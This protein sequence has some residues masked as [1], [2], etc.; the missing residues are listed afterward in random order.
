MLDSLVD[1]GRASKEMLRE[2][3]RSE[4]QELQER[5]EQAI[6]TAREIGASLDIVRANFNA[7]G[8]DIE[9]EFRD[10]L[11]DMVG[12]V[13]EARDKVSRMER[14]QYR[15]GVLDE[16][17]SDGADN[18]TL[19]LWLRTSKA[20]LEEQRRDAVAEARRLGVDVTLIRRLYNQKLVDLEKQYGD[21]RASAAQE[22]AERAQA[23]IDR[24]TDKQNRIDSRRAEVMQELTRRAEQARQAEQALSDARASL[25]SG[26]LA[27]GGPM[28]RLAELQRQFA[29]AIKA[30]KGG[31]V[32]AASR[33]GSLA[34]SLLQQGQQVYASSGSYTDLFQSVNTQLLAAQ[35]GFDARA[36]R[37]E[38]RLDAATFTSVTEKHTA[39]LL[40][41]LSRLDERLADVSARIE[42]QTNRL[43][44]VEQTRR[45][46]GK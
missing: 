35:G 4:L 37:I 21:L 36:D 5:R 38:S 6:R 29:E 46:G 27:P 12:A 22:A 32:D 23:V 41:A 19:K 28:D 39:A 1:T 8:K 45:V 9:K 16:L 40:R 13:G 14:L 31:D 33:A 26:D 11:A 44:R 10:M 17:V 15:G 25:A 24:L 18:G 2:W 34:S 7:Q 43:E 30:A 42:R 20:I 3:R